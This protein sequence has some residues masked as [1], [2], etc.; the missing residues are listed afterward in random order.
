MS[1]CQCVNEQVWLEV[2]PLHTG[3]VCFSS[4]LWG[5]TRG[6]TSKTSRALRPGRSYGE[7]ERGSELHFYWLT[8]FVFIQSGCFLKR[9]KESHRL[10]PLIMWWV[11]K[12]LFFFL[13]F[14]LNVSH[15]FIM[16][17]LCWSSWSSSV[18]VC[19]P[20]SSNETADFGFLTETLI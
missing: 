9:R 6:R 3:H 13:F 19:P 18:L 11:K 7:A 15:Y 10:L 16:W 20:K 4:Q 8:R 12:S 14:F 1:V 17:H 2:P 5:P